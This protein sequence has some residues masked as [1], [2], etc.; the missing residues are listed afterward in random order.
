MGPSDTVRQ[1]REHAG[2]VPGTGLTDV[3]ALGEA[4]TVLH[5][6]GVAWATVPSGTATNLNAVWSSGPGSVFAVGEK[7]AILRGP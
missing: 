3:W 1:D 2:A 4:G 5:W 6:N 7:G